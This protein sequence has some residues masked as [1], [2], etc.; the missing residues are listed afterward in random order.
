MVSIT[1]SQNYTNIAN[2]IRGKGVTGSFKPSEMPSAI[3]SIAPAI[4]SFSSITPTVNSTQGSGGV[5]TATC[6]FPKTAASMYIVEFS[7]CSGAG[8]TS[9]PFIIES[10]FIIID[11]SGAKIG[12]SQMTNALTVTADSSTITVTGTG[13]ASRD[14]YDANFTA[15]YLG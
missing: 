11:S 7:L 13:Q 12:G 5:V 3:G 15:G 1:D 10:A 6:Q 9:V 14:G 4:G 8:L 2:A